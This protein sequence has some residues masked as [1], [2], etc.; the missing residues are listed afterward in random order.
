MSSVSPVD[1]AQRA[2]AV[3]LVTTAELDSLFVALGGNEVELGE[4]IRFAIA[5]E[6]LT[7]FQVTRLIDDKRTG[8]FYGKNKLAYLIGVETHARV[9]RATNID[10][11]ECVTI[12][13]IR[14][15]F[16]DDTAVQEQFVRETK[17]LGGTIAFDQKRLY[18]V[19]APP[20]Q[21]KIAQDPFLISKETNN[22]P[23][24]VRTVSQYSDFNLQ[25]NAECWITKCSTAVGLAGD[26]KCQCRA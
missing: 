19:F 24:L 7:S 9:Y 20:E 11:E 16:A 26:I 8:Y 18:A 17:R 12:I 15:R 14:E 1:L 3:N 6:L 4:F 2:V 25:S 5:Q 10:T 21:L 23:N 22:H 13:V